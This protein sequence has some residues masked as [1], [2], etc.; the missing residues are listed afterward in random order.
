MQA[1]FM[2]GNFMGLATIAASAN[3]AYASFGLTV[4]L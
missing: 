4:G 3:G 2:M 1:D